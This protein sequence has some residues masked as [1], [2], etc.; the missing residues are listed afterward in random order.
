MP[1]LI[2]TQEAADR[3]GIS[4]R[5]VQA[6]IQAGRLAAFKVGRSYI[7]READLEAVRDR[8]PG[9]PRHAGPL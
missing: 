8:P 1:D 5:R 7:I 4:P 2:S 9:R 3:L 6:L